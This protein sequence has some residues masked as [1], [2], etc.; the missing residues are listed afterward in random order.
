MLLGLDAQIWKLILVLMVFPLLAV[1]L[2]NLIF[3]KR[4]GIE[5]HWGGVLFVL[6]AGIVAVLI[7]FD[8]V[9]L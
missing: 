3:R 9:R 5:K 6:L 4:G 7:V 8:K 1:G 2:L